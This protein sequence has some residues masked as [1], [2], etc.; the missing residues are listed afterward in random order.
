MKFLFLIQARLNS[1]RLPGKVL[2][3]LLPGEPLLDILLKRIG[4]V[5]N[6][7]P[8]MH[9]L[10]TVN[11]SDDALTDHLHR[12]GIQCFRGNEENVF[13]RFQDFLK[14]TPEQ[15]DYFFRIC[16]DNPLIEP[17]FIEQMIDV[18]ESNHGMYD[19]ISFKSSDGT[20]VIQNKYG[21]FCELIKKETFL[22]LLSESLDHYQ[23]EHVTPILYTD[24]VFTIKL[25]DIPREIELNELRY[26]I[27][28]I[29]DA[30][31]VRNIL[32]MHG[33]NAS[34]HDLIESLS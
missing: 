16:A 11:S 27:D 30:E 29:E 19:Y 3:D 6:S 7:T 31:K 15:C 34:Y 9:V 1:T 25:L 23:Q 22:N 18:A 20:P 14:Q 13:L 5:R 24:N 28:T 2:M 26:T 12:R 32:M 4:K 21:I 10:T 33:V 17:V 8:N